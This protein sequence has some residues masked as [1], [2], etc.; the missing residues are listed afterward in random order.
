[1]HSLRGRASARGAHHPRCGVGCESVE[2]G[3]IR[4][5]ST[6]VTAPALVVLVAACSDIPPTEPGARPFDA[7]AAFAPGNAQGGGRGLDAEFRRIAAETPGFAGM[8]YD[9]NGQLRV[10]ATRAAL[11]APNGRQKLMSSVTNSLRGNGRPMAAANVVFEE[12]E[13][14][15]LRLASM[16]E[17]MTALFGVDGVVYT[18]VD[19]AANRLRVGVLAGTPSERIETAL[20]GLDIPADIVNIETTPAI[21]RLS[22]ESLRDRVQP[23]GGGLQLVWE[24]PGIGFFLCTLGFNVVPDRPGRSEP[25]F[26][27]NSHCSGDQGVV[28]GIEYYQPLPPQFLPGPPKFPS[29]TAQQNLLGV[30]IADPPYFPCGGGFV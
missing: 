26:I 13:H 11:E 8:H 23:V 27:T 25:H 17:R 10:R 18:D 6:R 24:Y 28:T 3:R 4:A 16:H 15:Y 5:V 1:M 22:G 7:T 29:P 12:A 14:D 21:E 19:E 2:H 9:A 20:A 30:E